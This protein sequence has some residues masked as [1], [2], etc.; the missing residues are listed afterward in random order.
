MTHVN[1]FKRFDMPENLG[2][3]IENIF[4]QAT[5]G[6]VDYDS[7]SESPCETF[8]KYAHITEGS[9]IECVK[10]LNEFFKDNSTYLMENI[11]INQADITPVGD[12]AT[13]LTRSQ[14]NV[15]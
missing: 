8:R 11:M 3:L 1:P 9:F 2:A 14:S 13:L 6:N 5:L 12:C 10:E 4:H 7:D 15:A